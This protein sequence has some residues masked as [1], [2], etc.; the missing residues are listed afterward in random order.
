VS[1]IAGIL[2]TDGAP[3]DKEL[4]SAMTQFLAFRGPDSQRTQCANQIGLGH[5][6][7]TTTKESSGDEQPASLDGNI[8]ITADA[9]IDAR[10]S[11][12][13][14]LQR[15]GREV[16]IRTTDAQLIL[17]A[18][19]VWGNECVDH[20]LGDF[21]FAIW[22]GRQEKL[23]CARDQFGVKCFYYAHGRNFLTFSNTLDCVRMH[24][25]VSGQLNELSITD[26]LLF[27]ASQ[28]PGATS[29]S[30]IARLEPAHTLEL[31]GGKISLRRYWTLPASQPFVYKHSMEC[32]ER[33]Q[34]LM[35]TAVAD[36][37][38]TGPAAVLM[39]GGLDSSIV[40][41][42]ARRVLARPDRESNLRAFTEVY[43]HLIPHEER[44]F[45]GLAAEALGLPVEFLVA[46]DYQIFRG[47]D[48]ARGRWPEP[49]N[50]AWGAAGIDL[51]RKSAVT[52][53][54]ALTGHGGDPTLSGRLG[55]YFR[56][57]FQNGEL[58]RGLIDAY[59]YLTASKRF[60]RLYVRTRMRLWFSRKGIEAQFPDWLN[61][62]L[63]Q[64]FQL[65]QRWEHL[66]E[67]HE[68]HVGLGVRP[69][70]YSQMTAPLW[71][72]IFE[73]LD[74]GFTHIPV[75][76]CHP[77]F[78]LRLVGFLLSL[79]VLPWCSDKELLREAARGVLPDAVRLRRKSPLMEDPVVA[80]LQRP[81]SAWIDKF[82]AVPDFAQYVVR[83]RI[84]PVFHE[85]DSWAASINL[86][87]LSLNFWLQQPAPFRYHA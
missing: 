42:S 21:V 82:E 12:T 18:Y 30:D 50:W 78:D 71:P 19:H 1:G 28:E 79:P 65:Q 84:K 4:L 87:P 41:A 3:V 54:V 22:D 17:H 67:S 14:D 59:R 5:T 43:D 27:E 2:N 64:R 55:L 11:L 86:R 44:H 34:E 38:R 83:N 70:A 75:E 61:P 81:E 16:S 60:S 72:C 52:S 25:G 45:A 66:N 48:P 23:F 56:Q 40:A 7:L 10:L 35:D 62:E 51:I 68:S 29:F 26:F 47:A 37:V 20:L 39:S 74:A 9:R 15:N 24:P 36:R 58:R 53:R 69:L 31:Q 73:S 57:L 46:D 8:W 49:A 33:F 63:E 13:E 6:L 85:T 80:L 32:V 76:V 77:F